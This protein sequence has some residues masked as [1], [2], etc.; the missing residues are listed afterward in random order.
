MPHPP[1]EML[2]WSEMSIQ[3]ILELAIADEEEAREYYLHAAELA[4][5]SH[6]RRVLLGLADMEQ[7][8]AETLRKELVDLQLQRDLETGMAD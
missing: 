5:N 8:H 7:G 2:K 3:D 4:G 6:T 1:L